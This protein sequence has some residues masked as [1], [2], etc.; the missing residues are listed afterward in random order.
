MCVYKRGRGEG[1]KRESGMLHQL[2][3]KHFTHTKREGKAYT[4][5]KRVGE[6]YITVKKRREG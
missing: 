6:E 5:K 1:E 3:E 4:L 2:K